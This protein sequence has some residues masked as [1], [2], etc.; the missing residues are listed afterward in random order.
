MFML[1]LNSMPR[2]L[3]EVD[4]LITILPSLS[5]MSCN[6]LDNLGLT[7]TKNSVLESLSCNMLNAIHF[8]MSR[9]HAVRVAAA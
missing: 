9:I 5:E 8:F 1:W 3:T 2:F 7:A 6:L 4:G